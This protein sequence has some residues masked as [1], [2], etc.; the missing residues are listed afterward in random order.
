MFL[1][2]YSIN[3]R[4]MCAHWVKLPQLSST[5]LSVELNVPKTEKLD[6]THCNLISQY[7]NFMIS[8]FTIWNPNRISF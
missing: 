7:F 5:L 3:F 1:L 6:V 4:V 8:V 2:Q